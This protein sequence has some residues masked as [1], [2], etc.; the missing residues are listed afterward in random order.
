MRAAFSDLSR[1]AV[2][3]AFSFVFVIVA[4][5]G[6]H[7]VVGITEALAPTPA[8]VLAFAINFTLLRR[9]VF[10]GQDAPLG[11]QVAETAVTSVSFRAIEYGLFL[12]LH[13]G[14]DAS[15]LLAT[16]VSLGISA[17][18][19]FAVY[20]EI[21]FNRARTPRGSTGAGSRWEGA[22]PASSSSRRTPS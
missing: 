8:L 18:G 6:F 10:P 14:L 12:A 9:W 21:V 22:T 17:A 20:R 2:A 4:T 1:Y 13:L 5:A 16:A 11:R 15:Y 19:R 7:E 3:S